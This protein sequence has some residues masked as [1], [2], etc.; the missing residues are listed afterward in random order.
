VSIVIKDEN[1]PHSPKESGE[2]RRDNI[3][4]TTI[5]NKYMIILLKDILAVLI[6]RDELNILFIFLVKT[7]IF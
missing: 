4:V 7:Y 3:G 1:T 2:Y 6:I 5:G